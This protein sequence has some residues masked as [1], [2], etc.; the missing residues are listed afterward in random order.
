MDEGFLTQLESAINQ[1]NLIQD[2][3]KV[4]I[5]VSG[6]PDSVALLHGLLQLSGHNRKNWRLFVVHVN[7]QLRGIESQEDARFVAELCKTKKIPY[8]ICE[9]SVQEKIQKEGGNKQ[10]VARQLR[11][12]A[13][14][15][16]AKKWGIH[17]IALAHHAD[18]QVET[19]LMRLLRGTS[20]S[21]LAGM[22]HIREWRGLQIIRPMLHIFREDVERYLTESH[23]VSPRYDSSNDSLDYT[24]NRIRHQL[25]PELLTYNP[26]M[27]EALLR[28]SEITKS[29]EEIWMR[30]TEEAMKSTV[31][32]KYQSDYWLDVKKF[33]DLPV[34]LQRRTVKL[35]L[36]C[37]V[38][39]GR[40][41]ISLET[42]ERVR[43]FFQHQHPSAE[44]HIKGGIFVKKEYDQLWITY[45]PDKRTTE[46]PKP[47]IVRL[48]IPGVT[49]LPDY[50]GEMKGVLLTKQLFQIKRDKNTV[51]FDAEQIKQP[52]YVR[53]RKNGDR[54]SCFGLKG[55]KK[56]KD[57][58]I[59]AKLPRRKRDHYPIVVMG[60]QILWI[61]G[62]R[63]SDFA[64][65]TDQTKQVLYLVWKEHQTM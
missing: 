13:F 32:K 1:Y 30:L 6:G 28:L 29:E 37:L 34:A 46:K 47:P 23:F 5:G 55:S 12:D 42:I 53:P 49:Q 58:F 27:K 21:G 3:D 59:E 15:E 44:Y 38:R 2:N 39:N 50:H 24:R 25:I 4:L 14:Y 54:M 26:Q 43:N 56:I 60:D 16:T 65:V 17:K 51:A 63:R 62:I 64:P 41:E 31:I 48:K 9:V 10:A 57:L 40:S 11:Y 7:H 52:L 19:L 33:L 61:P 22:A 36:D 20:I 35:I 8:R 45:L 18:D